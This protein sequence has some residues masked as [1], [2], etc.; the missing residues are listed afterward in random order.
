MKI[1]STGSG[2]EDADDENVDAPRLEDEGQPVV[3]NSVELEQAWEPERA[4]LDGSMPIKF[5]LC[6]FL[7][8]SS[9]TEMIEMASNFFEKFG[10][11]TGEIHGNITAEEAASIAA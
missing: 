11:A 9:S 2:F 3:H 10:V 5:E 6:L 4:S 8:R 1:F 7:R